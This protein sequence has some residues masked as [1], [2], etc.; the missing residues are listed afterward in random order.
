MVVDFVVVVIIVDVVIVDIL[1]LVVA[2]NMK[3]LIEI[4]KYRMVMCLV[5]HSF[6]F[7]RNVLHPLF[8][9]NNCQ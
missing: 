5:H 1:V 6:I 9:V 3:T 7:L 8:F 4:A 2:L